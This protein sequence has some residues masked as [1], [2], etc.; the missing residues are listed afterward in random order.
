[1]TTIDIERREV[2][3]GVDILFRLLEIHKFLQYIR[4]SCCL[5]IVLCIG[6]YFVFD[7]QQG[8]VGKKVTESFIILRV[9]N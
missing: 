7:G 3:N 6:M 5:D 1:M 2:I 4:R 9:E 8:A